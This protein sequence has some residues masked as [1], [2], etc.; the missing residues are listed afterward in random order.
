VLLPSVV[1]HTL[2]NEIRDPIQVRAAAAPSAP[3]TIFKATKSLINREAE[4]FCLWR[5]ARQM[6]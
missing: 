4:T 5:A 6:L 2:M 3:A 1:E